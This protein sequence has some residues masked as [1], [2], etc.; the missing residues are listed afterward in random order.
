MKSL[1]NEARH[2]VIVATAREG[3]YQ[4]VA[5]RRAGISPSTL[6]Q[7]L[8]RGREAEDNDAPYDS[9][10]GKYRKL[11]EDVE[12]ATA[13]YEMELREKINAAARSEKPNTWQAAAWSLERTMPEKY[14]RR[15][16]Q[17]VEGGVNPIRH[18]TVHILANPEAQEAANELLKKLARPELSER[19]EIPALPMPSIE[20]AEVVEEEE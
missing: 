5:A 9:P 3:A 1:L 17:I 2:E 11:F 19:S 12:E 10:E 8:V 4:S 13:Q 6:Y 14:G 16:T 7:W 20:D 18:A 15:D